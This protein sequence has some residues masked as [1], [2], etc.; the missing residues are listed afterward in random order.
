MSKDN[1]FIEVLRL[2]TAKRVVWGRSY[3]C[4]RPLRSLNLP[5]LWVRANLK[6]LHLNL[7]NPVNHKK[8]VYWV[9]NRT[10]RH[11]VP[12]PVSFKT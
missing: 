6:V 12:S 11:E 9:F 2:E 5:S 4:L 3:Q 8:S 10:Y 1:R 7:S